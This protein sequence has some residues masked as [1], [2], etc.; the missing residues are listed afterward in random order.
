MRCVYVRLM[1]DTKTNLLA[2]HKAMA[3]VLD[4]KFAKVPEWHAFRAIDKALLALVEEAKAVLA[5]TPAAPSTPSPSP[6]VPPKTVHT[7]GATAHSKNRPHE[8]PSYVELGVM[9]LEKAGKPL[10]TAQMIEFIAQHRK[11]PETD[12]RRMVVNISSS[13]S[14]NE[15]ITNIPWSGGRAWWLADRPV[16]K[17]GAH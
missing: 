11:L 6:A 9:A 3:A 12:K 10:P 13:F 14:H 15:R 2:A 5:P 1:S 7:N 8:L 16:P 17:E 4:T